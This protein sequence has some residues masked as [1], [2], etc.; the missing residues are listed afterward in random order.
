M[1]KKARKRL[2][3]RITRYLEAWTVPLGLDHWH[4]D[5]AF[6]DGK[7]EGRVVTMLAKAFRWVRN[8]AERGELTVD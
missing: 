6:T 5:V 7:H 4:N 2:R 8:A 1:S 3:K